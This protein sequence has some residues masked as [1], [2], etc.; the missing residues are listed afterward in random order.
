MYA[1]SGGH[2]KVLSLLLEKGADFGV[3]T[4]VGKTCTELPHDFLLPFTFLVCLYSRFVIPVCFPL[5]LSVTITVML[6]PMGP[7]GS[8]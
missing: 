8:L 5:P 7:I 4:S 1:V 3:T 2:T 6:G